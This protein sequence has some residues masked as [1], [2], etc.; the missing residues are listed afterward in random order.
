M[1]YLILLLAIL[2]SE[3]EKEY[4]PNGLVSGKIWYSAEFKNG[5]ENGIS[6]AYY[7]NGK[8]SDEIPYNN[9]KKDGTEK[10]YDENGSI[11]FEIKNIYYG[12]SR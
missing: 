4:F 8:I 7:E 11:E 10:H 12:N 6:K 5:K 3:I 2:N 1:K 9:G